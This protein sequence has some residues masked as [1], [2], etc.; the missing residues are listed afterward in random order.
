MR[1]I[2]IRKEGEPRKAAAADTIVPY[3]VPY[4]IPEPPTTSIPEERE[5]VEP[6][7]FATALSA[8]R[9]V[10]DRA[11][12]FRQAIDTG[13]VGRDVTGIVSATTAGI[14]GVTTHRESLRDERPVRPATL[15]H[16]T[17]CRIEVEN[18]IR[19][20]AT[21]VGMSVTVNGAPHRF[22]VDV[23]DELTLTRSTSAG[24]DAFKR[25]VQADLMSL[26]VDEVRR[27]LHTHVDSTLDNILDTIGAGPYGRR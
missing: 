22:L 9:Q 16:L 3:D 10:S 12:A 25:Y 26:L 23:P 5:R 21:V 8:L 2:I 27:V 20:R 13:V 24:R 15:L 14:T 6:N 18:D 7:A 17:N 11:V 19:R 1:K 4:E